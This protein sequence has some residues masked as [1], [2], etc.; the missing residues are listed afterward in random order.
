MALAR[1]SKIFQDTYD[2]TKH[3]FELARSFKREDKATLSKRIE[4]TCL[5]LMEL[6]VRANSD[7]QKRYDTLGEFL[8]KYEMLKC[9]VRLSVDLR[10]VSVAQQ[11]HIARLMEGIGRQATGWRKSAMMTQ[12]MQ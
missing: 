8:V 7:K 6:V 12:K 4:D 9:L 2:L 1:D 3:L 10:D 11:A 5:D